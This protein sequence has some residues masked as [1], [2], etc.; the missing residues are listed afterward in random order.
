MYYKRTTLDNGLR[1]LTAPMPG[2][3]SASIA[4]FFLVG[5]RYE[6]RE[7]AGV[8]HFIEHMLFKGTQQ[9]PTA[10]HISEAIEGVG[11]SFNGSTSKEITNYTARVPGQ[12]LDEVMHVLANMVR[13]P[14]FEAAEIEK[15]R[16][17]IIE[18]LRSTKDEPQE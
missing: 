11:G 12:H 7:L 4:L 15:E 18:E 17:V 2:M 3:R 13:Y 14:L 10:R 8:S 9:Y 1:L 5:S 6:N 16:N